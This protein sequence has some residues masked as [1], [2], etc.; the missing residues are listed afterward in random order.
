MIENNKK[1]LLKRNGEL[2]YYS[3]FFSLQ[4][5][6]HFYDKLLGDTDWQ[7]RQIYVFG[8]KVLQPRLM[9]WQGTKAYSYSGIALEPAP[10]N[11]AVLEIKSRVEKVSGT[12][13]NSALLNYY[14]GGSDSMGWHRDNEKELGH[15]PCIASVSFGAIRRFDLRDYKAK[16]DKL[17]IHLENG[18]LLMMKGAIQDNWEH[19]VPKT[20]KVN[21]GRINITFRKI[22]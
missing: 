6:E 7:S 13:F 1:N 20:K 21:E 8:R 19:S 2:Y 11:N 4:E 14:R 5:S 22:I 10:F 17:S 16:T 3:S 18:S 15:G 12:I 9:S